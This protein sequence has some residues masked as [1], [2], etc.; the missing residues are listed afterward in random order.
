MY[1][2]FDTVFESFSN[3]DS[4]LYLVIFFV[5]RFYLAYH[6]YNNSHLKQILARLYK[7]T[8]PM[9]VIDSYDFSKDDAYTGELCNMS[10]INY[11]DDNYAPPKRRLFV[12]LTFVL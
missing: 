11:R 4:W 10:F 8:F 6:G 5:P 12:S 3:E 9:S 7:N 2:N 1:I